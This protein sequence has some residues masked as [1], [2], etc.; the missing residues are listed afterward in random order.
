M[1]ADRERGR[2]QRR[3]SAGGCRGA[4]ALSRFQRQRVSMDDRRMPHPSRSAPYR[5]HPSRGRSEH[6]SA[7]ERSFRARE[8]ARLVAVALR[9]A[10]TAG[11]LHRRGAA[12]A[13]SVAR[14]RLA[15]GKVEPLDRVLLARGADQHRVAVG[16]L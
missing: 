2:A 14:R 15:S 11:N 3:S 8:V 7:A 13:D 5:R 12:G 16:N 6:G 1:R 4:P 10:V 9:F